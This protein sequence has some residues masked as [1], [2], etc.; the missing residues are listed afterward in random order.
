MDRKNNLCKIEKCTHEGRDKKKCLIKRLTV[1]KKM[2][3]F[4]ASTDFGKNLSSI[5][6]IFRGMR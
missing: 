6:Y 4:I 3:L 2:L 5:T 1:E